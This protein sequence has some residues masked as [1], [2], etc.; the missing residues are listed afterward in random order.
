[1]RCCIHPGNTESLWKAVKV[2]RDVNTN[3]LPQEM[4]VG[5]LLTMKEDLPQL[6][7]KFFNDK[8]AG[9]LEEVEIDEHVFTSLPFCSFLYNVVCQDLFKLSLSDVI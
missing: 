2:A 4:F 7:A 3:E 6:F 1:M 8:V 9:L 5:G